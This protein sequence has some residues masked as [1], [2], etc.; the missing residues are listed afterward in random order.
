MHL[1]HQPAHHHR[2]RNRYCCQLRHCQYQFALL[3]LSGKHLR[4]LESH[5]CHH[6]NPNY[7]QVHPRRSHCFRKD[8]WGTSPNRRQHH[9]SRNLWSPMNSRGK[10][11]HHS[12]LRLRH[13]PRQI[14][15]TP[16]SVKRLVQNG[17]YRF[18]RKFH[19]EKLPRVRDLSIP[20]IP[21]NRARAKVDSSQVNRSRLEPFDHSPCQES[22]LEVDLLLRTIR[23]QIP[24]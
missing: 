13:S 24:V 19:E 17:D 2:R 6:L 15:T 5:R 8:R 18:G 4:R 14:Y 16:T 22:I 7:H 1:V 11:L 12:Q 23:E 21:E 3:R 10:S 20:Q 9:L